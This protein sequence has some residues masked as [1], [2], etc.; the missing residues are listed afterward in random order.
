MCAPR[1]IDADLVDDER[2]AGLADV[3]ADRLLD[4]QLVAGIEAELDAILADDS[5]YGTLCALD[6]QPRRIA[7]RE[8]LAALRAFADRIAAI[9]LAKVVAGTRTD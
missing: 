7:A 3:V 4:L 1:R 5:F 6:P 2:R 9:I 8:T